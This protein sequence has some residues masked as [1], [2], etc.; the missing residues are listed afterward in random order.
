MQWSKVETVNGGNPILLS[1]DDKIVYQGNVNVNIYAHAI[2]VMSKLIYIEWKLIF[3][4]LH[5]TIVLTVKVSNIP[6]LNVFSP[7]IYS[8][9]F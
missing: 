6:V 1:E 8:F 5:N 7:G 4:L 2:F 3:S 9:A